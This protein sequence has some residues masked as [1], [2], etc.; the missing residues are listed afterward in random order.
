M[1][2]SIKG[3]QRVSSNRRYIIS[4]Q[5]R[6]VTQ[7]G[8]SVEPL[9]VPLSPGLPIPGWERGLHHGAHLGM[10]C[11]KRLGFISC[12][13]LR[14]AISIC[15]PTLSTVAGVVGSTWNTESRIPNP[16][17]WNG[18]DFH[19]TQREIRN[20]Q[21]VLSLDALP[22]SLPSSPSLSVCLSLRV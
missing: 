13:F 11:A 14:A 5:R 2:K 4:A 3:S 7:L 18:V 9:L 12:V 15:N 20:Q 1:L 17:C 21:R 8:G 16:E 6:Q 10:G 19:T 22:T